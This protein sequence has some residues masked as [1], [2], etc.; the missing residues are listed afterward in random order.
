MGAYIDRTGMVFG[1]LTVLKRKDNQNGQKVKWE[2]RCQCGEIVEK[3]SDALNK[4]SMC[5]NCASL[6]A[7]GA[8]LDPLGNIHPQII[9]E[10]GKKYNKLT[11]LELDFDK[12]KDKERGGIF[13]K[14]QC[15]CGKY[16]TVNA[17]DLRKGVVA[18]C[19]C[20]HI[21]EEKIG[22]KY[23]NLTI[24]KR[25]ENS[26]A[27]KARYL[28]RCDCGNSCEVAGSD[29]RNGQQFSCGCLKSKGELNITKLLLQHSL[30]YKKEVKFATCKDKKEL[31]FDFQIFINDNDFYLIEFDGKQHF[32][33]TLAWSSFSFEK[34][35]KHDEIKNEWCKE[36]NI[37]LIRIPYTH[38]NDLC[39]EDLLLK[40]SQFLIH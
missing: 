27:G 26:I 2:C 9:D 11:V 13:W 34:T 40:T 29:L 10:R 4:T 3:R 35:K 20:L 16:K 5:K 14:C 17:S 39:I 37:P 6:V 30:S 32:S 31:P 15:D 1:Y 23:G 21:K 8:L 22:S 12:N 36:N 24:I 28:C 33:D 25:I 19:G 18:S 38:L 7:K